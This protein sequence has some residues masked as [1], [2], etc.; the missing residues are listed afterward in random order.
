MG[1]ALDGVPRPSPQSRE[2]SYA[3][4][5]GKLAST[6]WP[7]S[8]LRVDLALPI[9]GSR[10]VHAAR[11]TYALAVAVIDA[12]V[13]RR[14]A[15]VAHSLA[16]EVAAIHVAGQGWRRRA[17]ATRTAICINVTVTRNAHV[18][19]A[20]HV[21]SSMARTGLAGRTVDVAHTLV[22]RASA[23][24][25]TEATRAPAV[26][27]RICAIPVTR[28]RPLSLVGRGRTRA[29]AG[30]SSRRRG[31][32]ALNTARPVVCGGASHDGAVARRRV[33]GRCSRLAATTSSCG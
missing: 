13:L 4:D 21:G 19:R 23:A 16:E 9:A 7:S 25:W 8:R 6:T 20:K 2:A 27:S 1:S 32:R 33:P 28:A 3:G 11:E 17:V 22:V 12:L 15:V 31:L 5:R 30:A 24:G 29:I 10:V 14:V 18:S 26:D